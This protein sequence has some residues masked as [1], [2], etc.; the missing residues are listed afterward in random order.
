[1]ILIIT[2]TANYVK[3][4]LLHDTITYHKELEV[5]DVKVS[6]RLRQAFCERKYP[7]LDIQQKWAMRPALVSS[8]ASA[9]VKE[10]W[11]DWWHRVVQQRLV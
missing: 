2:Q 10:S 3:F 7:Q 8:A 1:M 5:V 11:S 9:T 6:K 4:G